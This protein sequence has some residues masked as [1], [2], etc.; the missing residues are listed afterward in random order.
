[1]QKVYLLF[2]PTRDKFCCRPKT[3]LLIT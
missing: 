3:P 2:Q 1:V